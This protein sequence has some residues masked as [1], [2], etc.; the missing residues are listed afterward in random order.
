VSEISK[1]FLQENSYGNELT[2][3]RINDIIYIYYEVLN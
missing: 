2:Q 3:H 1:E